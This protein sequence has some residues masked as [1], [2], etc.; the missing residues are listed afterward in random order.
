MDEEELADS[1][2]GGSGFAAHGG[3]QRAAKAQRRESPGQGKPP[4]V[5]QP[6]PQVLQPPPQVLQPP[7]Q[8]LQ[9]LQPPP[10][11]L[12]PLQPPPQVL[13]TPPLRA[14]LPRGES[15]SHD[16]DPYTLFALCALNET[17]TTTE[18]LPKTA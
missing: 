14:T 1:T 4:Q 10:Q 2:T 6:P 5:L 9:P 17:E 7:P 3:L 11:V 18:L 16:D 13:K 15:P 8:V 12:Q